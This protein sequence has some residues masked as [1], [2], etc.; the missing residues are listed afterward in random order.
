MLPGGNQTHNYTYSGSDTIEDVAWYYS[1]SGG[2]T[3]PLGTRAANEL[4]TL[5]MSGNVWEWCWDIYSSYP[6]EPQTDPHGAVSGS[7]RV[8]R[9]GCWDS[10]ASICT[11]DN[12]GN[13]SA[14]S[15]VNLIGF[16]VVRVSS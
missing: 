8:L 6:S 10:F 2:T 4:G 16:R 12:R 7:Y 11:V 1:N 9:G 13:V 5:D 14:T 3:H 15:T